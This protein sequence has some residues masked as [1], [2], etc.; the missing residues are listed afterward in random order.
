MAC[1]PWPTDGLEAVAHCPYCGG[2]ERTLAHKGVEDWAFGCAPGQWN[3]WSCGRCQSLYLHPRPTAAT[4]G[5]AYARYYTHAGAD[6]AGR[7][8][9]WKQRLRN[10]WWSH[11]LNTSIK[12]RL[13]LPRALGWTLAWLKP[14]IAEPFGLRQWAQAPKGLLID[15]GCGN[16]EKLKLAAQLGWQTLGI[17]MDASA[18]H[19]AQAQGLCHSWRVRITGAVCRASC[20]C[21]VLACVGTRAPASAHAASVAGGSEARGCF[22]TQR[23]KRRE[24]FAPALWGELAWSGG[25]SALG[26]SRCSLAERL[27]ARPRLCMHAGAILCVGDGDRIGAHRAKSDRCNPG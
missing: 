16:G 6:G 18:V 24:P 11:T 4:I 21:G 19:A 13:G 26:D 25:A 15:V 27:A 5:R 10:E 1:E 2:A 9:G 23:P 22:A 17:E 20:L 8:S 3:Y 7:L 12:P 14:H